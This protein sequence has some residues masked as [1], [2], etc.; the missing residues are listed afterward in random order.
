MKP[1]YIAFAGAFAAAALMTSTLGAS[2]GVNAAAR[3]AAVKNYKVSP[4]LYHG[5]RVNVTYRPGKPMSAYKVRRNPNLTYVIG[6]RA[7]FMCTP[8]GFGR[9]STCAGY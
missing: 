6:G 2:A 7:P 5:G 1:L 8:S 4:T 3:P 9:R